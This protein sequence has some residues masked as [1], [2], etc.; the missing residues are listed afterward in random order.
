MMVPTNHPIVTINGETNQVRGHTILGQT[1]MM[2]PLNQPIMIIMNRETASH[3]GVLHVRTNPYMMV[4]KN[5]DPPN[6]TVYQPFIS[7][8][9]FLESPMAWEPT[10]YDV[11]FAVS[12]VRLRQGSPG[13][14]GAVSSHH[15]WPMG[16]WPG[17]TDGS[18]VPAWTLYP[19]L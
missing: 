17:S 15:L 2:V 1:H 7:N 8:H 11:L 12:H 5:R 6:H 14:R 4:S 10:I 9:P 16:V 19:S 3:L 18:S 13:D